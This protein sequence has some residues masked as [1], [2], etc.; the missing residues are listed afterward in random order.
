MLKKK[1]TIMSVNIHLHVSFSMNRF[2]NLCVSTQ[3]SLDIRPGH[4]KL[5]FGGNC[6]TVQW[7]GLHVSTAG[8]PGS[9]PGQGTTIPQATWPKKAKNK[10]AIF[11][12]QKWSNNM[13]QKQQA[14]V[15]TGLRA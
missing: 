9:I 2:L 1:A 4:T 6:L 5:P 13:V 11:V 15:G 14:H 10:I 8:G 3:R 7:L 12:Y